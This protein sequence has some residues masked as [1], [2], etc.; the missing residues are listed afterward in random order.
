MTRTDTPHKPS[1]QWMVRA[2]VDAN[3]VAWLE[4]MSGASVPLHEFH[5]KQRIERMYCAGLTNLLSGPSPELR[6]LDLLN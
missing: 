4:G 6:I 5:A 2:G 3:D 1:L